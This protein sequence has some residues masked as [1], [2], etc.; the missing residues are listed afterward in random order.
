MLAASENVA[1]PLETYD[2]LMEEHND[3]K[4]FIAVISDSASL[5]W[6]KDR[7]VIDIESSRDL[8]TLFRIKYPVTYANRLKRLQEEAEEDA[9]D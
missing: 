9:G 5:S 8:M 4:E 6:D 1:I 7:L 3:L 2:D